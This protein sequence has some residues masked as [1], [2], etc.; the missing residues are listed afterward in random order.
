[1]SLPGPEEYSRA[2]SMS[3][4]FNERMKCK[5]KIWASSIY[6]IWYWW[7][8]KGEGRGDFNCGKWSRVMQRFRTPLSCPCSKQPT[9]G[10]S[11][12][13]HVLLIRLQSSC[14]MRGPAGFTLACSPAVRQNA[15]VFPLKSGWKSA[16][17]SF[18]GSASVWSCR[19]R[20]Y[21]DNRSGAGFISH[22][23]TQSN[24]ELMTVPLFSQLFNG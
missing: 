5:K 22:G 21:F 3:S 18:K 17:Y 19:I 20:C 23:R 13:I 16:V 9:K 2:P 10:T 4:M 11:I 12:L 7:G 15:K 6:H 1:M 14:R 24:M 8:L